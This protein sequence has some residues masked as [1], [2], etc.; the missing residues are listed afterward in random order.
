M[1]RT[2]TQTST[3]TRWHNSNAATC[4][5]KAMCTYT[6]CHGSSLLHETSDG[7]IPAAFT[8]VH[9]KQPSGVCPAWHHP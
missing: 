8:V 3:D 2:G 4:H 6:S 1:N 5:G 7:I 9:V